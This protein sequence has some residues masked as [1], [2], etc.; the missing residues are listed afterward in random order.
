MTSAHGPFVA[1]LVG[2]SRRTRRAL[3][4]L[5]RPARGHQVLISGD[6]ELLSTGVPQRIREGWRSPAVAAIQDRVFE[7]ILT[8]MNSGEPREDFRALA[9][10]VAATKAVH[11]VILEV[12]CASGWNRDVLNRL[13]GEPFRYVGIDYSQEMIRKARSRTKAGDLIVG[14]A[15]SLPC[16]SA[17]CDILVSG[18]V[19]MHIPEYRQA[20][21]ESRRVTRRWCVFHTV[22]VSHVRPTTL[23]SKIAYGER[24]FEVVF[25]EAELLTCLD[26]AGLVVRGTYD[27]VPYD[28]SQVLGEPT[29]SR[30][31]LCE[32]VG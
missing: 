4:R 26:E 30:T 27:S 12:G 22:P 7:P 8:R 6:Y 3:S 21:L 13:W 16:R 24:V 10:A 11:P 23:L 1:A 29:D 20:I 14:D 5:I 31:Y 25:N 19:L 9:A 15:V 2:V 28:L 17:S 18:S 32:A